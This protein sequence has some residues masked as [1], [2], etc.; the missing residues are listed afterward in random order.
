[1]KDGIF[2]YAVFLMQDKNKNNV[3]KLRNLNGG[4]IHVG[5]ETFFIFHIKSSISI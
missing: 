3:A 1:M 5:D 4:I 2:W